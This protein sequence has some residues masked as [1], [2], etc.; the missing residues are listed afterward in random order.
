MSPL[1]RV[2][3]EE[4][5]HWKRR[6]EAYDLQFNW[7]KIVSKM[8]ES[9]GPAR[10]KDKCRNCYKTYKKWYGNLKGMMNLSGFGRD[11]SKNTVT[12][13]PQVWEDTIKVSMKL[14]FFLG[15]TNVLE[16]MIIRYDY[17]CLNL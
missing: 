10:K 13:K 7:L 5:E 9:L 11:P 8:M 12:A 4:N 15:H 17:I 1:V 14:I 3:Y 16:L 6:S 2:S